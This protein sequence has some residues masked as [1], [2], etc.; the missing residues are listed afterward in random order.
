MPGSIDPI[1]EFP[2]P[3]PPGVDIPWAKAPFTTF[4]LP[5]YGFDPDD[6]D[7]DRRLRLPG[8]IYGENVVVD[9]DPRTEQ[10]T[11]ESGSQVWA[12]MNGVRFRN[13]IPPY[14]ESARF[15]VTASGCAPGQLISLRLPRPWSRP[16][17]LE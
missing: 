1:P 10:I 6:P 2:W 9:T 16:W 12:R 17:G 7:S 15:K 8:L 5:D 14:T 4:M 13:H 11:S 3:F